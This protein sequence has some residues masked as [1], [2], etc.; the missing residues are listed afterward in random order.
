MKKSRWPFVDVTWEDAVSD[1]C[2]L[3][4]DQLPELRVIQSRGW[5]II[6]DKKR[7]TIASSMNGLTKG[8][9]AVSE[10]TSIPRGCIVSIKKL[11]A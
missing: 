6:K 8:L 1:S 2:W 4:L 10:V 7:V 3:T 11:G 5:M 9:E